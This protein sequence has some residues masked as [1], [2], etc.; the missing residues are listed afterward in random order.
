MI[1]RI[2]KRVSYANIMLTL[3]LVF[4]MS[5]GAFAASKFLVTSTKQIKPSVLNQLRGK[6]GTNGLS[7]PA[8]ATGPGGPQGPAGPTGPAGGAGASGTSVEASS[9]TGA[10]VPCTNGGATLKTAD[11]AV[12]LCNGKEGKE[13]KEGSPWTAGGTL[14]TGAT[15][16]GMWGGNVNN[17]VT[18]MPISFSIPLPHALEESHAHLIGL[19]EG[20]GE[21]KESPA[22]KTGECKGTYTTPGAS[23][24]NLCIFLNSEFS[25]T[26]ELNASINL[27][28][29]PSA[30]GAGPTGALLVYSVAKAEGQLA[31]GTWAV[32]A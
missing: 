13:G 29:K 23:S 17:T 16:T 14:P 20:Q 27:N 19:E 11:T 4:A 31:I 32:T 3:I 22:I 21:P 25:P 30:G 18:R 2:G 26:I 15:E 6:P 9:F 7:G 12:N 5:G 28:E 10:K 1:A 8:G 24:G